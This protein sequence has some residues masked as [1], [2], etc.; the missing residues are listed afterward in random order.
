MTYE[1]AYAPGLTE[2]DY[3][4]YGG[5]ADLIYSHEPEVIIEGPAETGKTMA[6]CWK[7]HLICLKY[8]GAQGAIIR[9][10]QTSVYGSVLQTFERV[11]EGAP[12]IKYGGEKPEK[13]IYSNGSVIWVGGMDNRERVLSS[14]RDFIQTCQTEEFTLDDWEYLTT[15]TTGRGAIIPHPQLFGDCNP[16]GSKHWIRTREHVRLIHTTHRDNPTLYNRDGTMTAQGQRTMSRL[17][18]LSGVRRRRLFEGIW[19]TAEGAV[20]DMFDAQ[21]HV[22]RRELSEFHVFY[23][24]MDEGYTNPAVILLMGEDSDG[25]W[26]AFKEFYRRGVLQETVVAKAKDWYSGIYTPEQTAEQKEAG[27]VP[28]PVGCSFAAVDSAAAG[29]IA[30]M[31][32]NGMTAMSAKGRVLDGIQAIQNRLKV[33]GD[34]RPRLTVDPACV[35]TINEFE[36]Y[37]W[38][39]QAN[40]DFTKDEPLKEN[41]HA[42]DAIRY[43]QDAVAG[44]SGETMI[45]ISS[46]DW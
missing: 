43:L 9:K 34:G 33:Q 14:E 16:A 25:R 41:D 6:A 12:I 22:L 39:K 23:L 18:A 38:K 3:T 46:L 29:L 1:I 36:S 20:Y 11:S 32:N 44:S 5:N 7:S 21:I 19:A 27:L 37:V 8:P 13:Y 4:P 40:R 10:T 26:H 2:T 30:D 42:M 24:A 17:A 45:D 15:R 28:G 35:E 31:R